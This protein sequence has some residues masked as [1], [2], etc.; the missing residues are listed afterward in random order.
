MLLRRITQH[1]ND[2][3]WFAVWIDFIIVVIGVF[4]GIQVANW[5]DARASKAQEGAILVQLGDEFSEIKEALE[6]QISVRRTYVNDIGYLIDSLE[7]EVPSP[8]ETVIK[9]ALTAA[10]STGRRPASSSAYLQLMSNSDLARLS[11]A[12]L[13]RALVQYHARLERDA[14][15]FPQLMDMVM[16]EMSSNEYVDYDP[17]APGPRGAAIDE[18]GYAEDLDHDADRIRSYDLDGL[19]NY[20]QRYETLSTL[21]SVLLDTDQTQ[22][23]LANE[24]LA[25]ISAP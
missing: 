14:F 17:P 24:I 12:N 9:R 18:E 10:R 16:L 5:N 6:K 23:D 21:H 8:D 13:K 3:N 11:N 2:Q 19:R 7:G 22:L 25:Q 1:V 15:I 20:E 4:I